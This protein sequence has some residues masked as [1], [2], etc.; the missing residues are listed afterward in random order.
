VIAV[1]LAGA[2]C[3]LTPS[4]VVDAHRHGSENLVIVDY[5]QN[6]A[7]PAFYFPFGTPDP[8]H[9][10]KEAKVAIYLAPGMSSVT[11]SFS[12]L[13]T[14][15]ND[16]QYANCNWFTFA[17]AT[18]DVGLDVNGPTMTFT[19]MSVQATCVPCDD[20]FSVCGSAP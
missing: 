7:A 4:I 1:V 3:T 10:P 11:M 19:P 18:K 12:S 8:N 17:A 13:G 15:A 2:G 5:T 16:I 6:D 9:P 20:G 14:D